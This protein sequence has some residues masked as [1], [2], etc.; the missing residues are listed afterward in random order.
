MRFILYLD[1]SNKI[2]IGIIQKLYNSLYDKDITKLLLLNCFVLERSTS[3]DLPRLFLPV[4]ENTSRSVSIINYIKSRS[5]FHVQFFLQRSFD[6]PVPQTLK[7][8]HE[9]FINSI[10]GRTKR[11]RAM[12]EIDCLLQMA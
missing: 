5:S 12:I 11:Q 6:A 10:F 2:L 1:L 4:I 9:G 7:V 3:C 8:L